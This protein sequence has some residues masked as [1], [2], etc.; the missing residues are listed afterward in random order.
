MIQTEPYN[1]DLLDE[2]I[3][4]TETLIQRAKNTLLT[5]YDDYADIQEWMFKM[6]QVRKLTE[7]SLRKYS[8]KG[9]A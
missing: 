9:L 8:A 3:R 7:I 5:Y 1:T 6:E 2:D 4:M